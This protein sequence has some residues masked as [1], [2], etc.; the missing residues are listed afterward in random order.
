MLEKTAAMADVS[1]IENLKMAKA[2]RRGYLDKK[3]NTKTKVELQVTKKFRSCIP[4]PCLQLPSISGLGRSLQ[5]TIERHR[6]GKRCFLF[7][8]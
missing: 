3:A 6:V 2:E 5:F 8:R 1:V 7:V 4:S